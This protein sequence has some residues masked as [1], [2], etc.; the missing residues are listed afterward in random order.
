MLVKIQGLPNYSKIIIFMLFVIGIST[1]VYA[2]ETEK[3]LEK[4]SFAK[5][6]F[7]EDFKKVNPPNRTPVFRWDFSEPGIEHNYS[8]EQ[9]VKMKNDM[10]SS[11]GGGE[12][13]NIEQ[14]MSTKG[15]LII[16]S[17]GNGT[18][19]MVLKDMK[20]SMG[21][22][23]SETMAQ[24]MPPIVVQEVNEDGSGSFGDNS[25]DMM[26]KTLFPLPQ[27]PINVGESVDIPVQMPFNAMGS[28]LQATGRSHITLSKYVMVGDRFCAKF[29]VDTVISEMQI[30]KEIKGDYGCSVKGTSVF[31]FDVENRVFVSGKIAMLMTLSVDA[32]MPKTNIPEEKSTEMPK[33]SNMT[34]VNDNF[35]QVELQK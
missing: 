10:Q 32:P 29:N 6:V 11:F 28:V 13:K 26:L 14:E 23:K 19:K 4:S 5:E 31:Y 15:K 33:S 30:P 24:Q 3:S 25:L 20:M 34:M 12:S 18:A 27:Q 1:V 8:Y 9:K 35:V 21:G 2:E 16:K 22:S 17:Q 7:Q